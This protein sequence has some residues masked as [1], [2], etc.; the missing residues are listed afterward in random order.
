MANNRFPRPELLLHPNIPKPL[1]GINPR[2]ILGQKWWNARRQLA[3]AEQD[4]HCWAC[5]VHKTSAKYHQWLEAH[6]VYNIDYSTGRVEME[7]ICALCHSCH[8]YIHDGRMQKLL[9][10]GK[11][12]FEKYLD[13]LA[14]GERIVKAYLRKVAVNY[15]GEAWKQPFEATMPFQDTF[16]N[17]SVPGLPRPV[18]SSAEWQEWHLVVE[19]QEYYT[20]FSDI[21]E[22][23]DYYQWLHRNNLTDNFQIFARFKESK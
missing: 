12:S 4:Y 14:H 13:I 11:L 16:P 19:G 21:Q 1:H 15:R 23:A 17:V 9:E 3:Y 5:G 22:W 18:Q 8:Q 7:D 10:Q 6:E 20:R 2:T